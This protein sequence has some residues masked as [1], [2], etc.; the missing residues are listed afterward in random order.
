MHEKMDD[1]KLL[2]AL[3]FAI[4]IMA[5]AITVYLFSK[6]AIE[7]NPIMDKMF[8]HGVLPAFLFSL[9]IWA[10]FYVVLI[11]FP[12]NVKKDRDIWVNASKYCC[13]LLAVLTMIDFIN[14]Y[15]WLMISM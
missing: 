10:L 7:G 12:N 8:S 6:G 3:A 14:D 1:R 13:A 15:I 11:Y 9:L 4:N 5:F 2:F